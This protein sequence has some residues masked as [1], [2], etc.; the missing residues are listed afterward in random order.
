[1]SS[2]KAPKGVFHDPASGSFLQRKKASLGN[3][4]HSGDEKNVFLKSGSGASIYSDMESLSGNN[5]NVSMSGGFDGFLL[6][7]AVNTPKTKRVNTGV[8]FG[9]PIGSLD[10]K[11]DEEVKPLP[12]PLRKKVLLDKIWINSKV[13]KTPVE[14]SVKK[15]FALDI[16]LSAVEGKSAMKNFL[17]NQWFWGATTPLKFKGII[18]SMFTSEK[19]MEMAASLAREN[20]IVINTNLKK[21]GV[22]SDRAVVIKEI[23]MDTPK[24]IIVATA[25]EFGEIRSIKIQLIGIWQ[26]AVIEFTEL[27]QAELLVSKWSFL[28]GKNSV[29]VAMAVG[30]LKTTAHNLGTLLDRTGGRT[31]IINHSLD[32]GSRFCCAV[33]GFESERDL[34]SA[35]YT[36][37]I[38]G[39]VRL[40]WARL[41]LVQCG[42]C[43]RF[44]HLALEY[45][46]STNNMPSLSLAKFSK[47]FV[48][49]KRHLQ[50]AKLYPFFAS[51]LW[52]FASIELVPLV[53]SSLTCL[54]NTSASLALSLDSD[55]V[56]D[57]ASMLSAPHPSFAAIVGKPTLGLSSSKVLTGK[58]KD[59]YESVCIFTSGL[60]IG[61]LSAGVAIIMNNSLAHY[62]SKVEK[63]S[64]QVVAVWLLFKNKLSVSV[65]GLYAVNFLITKAVNSSTFVVL[66]E[67]F[68][69]NGSRRSA[70]FR[71]CLSLGLVNS[72]FGHP[73][74]GTTTWDNSRRVER[75]I[76]FIFVSENLVSAVAGHRVG[77]VSDFFDTNYNAVM[78]SVGLDGLLNVHLNS[79]CK[80]TNKDHWKFN[81]KN[82]NVTGQSRFRNCSSVMVL[83]MKDDFLAA[84]AEQDLDCSKNK[85]SSKFLC[86]ELLIIKIVKKFSTANTLGFN[87][88]VRKWSTLDAD[89]AFVLMDIVQSGWKKIAILKFLSIIK[90]KYRKFKLYESKLAQKASIREAIEKHMEKFCSDKSSMIRSVLD[91]PF[92][93]V[94][95][96]HL[97]IDDELVLEPKE[98]MPSMLPDL[99]AHQ[100]A[101]LAHVK[102]NAFFGVMSTITLDELLLV[103]GGL[104]NSKAAGLSGISNKLWKWGGKEVMKCLLVLLNVY[105]SVGSVPAVLTNTHPITLIEMARK[106]LSKILSDRI[107]F[108]CSRFG[109]LHGDNFLVLK[110]TS[111]QFPVFAVGSVVKNALEKN[112]ELLHCI[113]M[114]SRFIDFFGSIYE[115][116]VN[117][118]MTDFGF[119]S[120]YR[121]HDGLDQGEVFS[122]LLWRIF[123]DLLLCKVKRHEYLCGYYIDTKFVARTDRIENGGGMSSFFAA[124]TF[125]D[126]MIWIRDCQAS[127]QYALNIASE[128]F[129]IND[130]S[131][132]NEKRV[133]IPINQG[134]KI[135][136]LSINNQPISITKK[137]KA[138]RYLGI[139]LSTEEL[140]K[141]SLAKT[142]SDVCF[143]VNRVLRK[144]IVSY[145]M[146]FSFISSGICCKWDV[147]VRKGFRS[148]TH[149]PRH[150]PD[151]ALHHSS[152]YGLKSFEQVQSEEKMAFLVS[153]ANASSVLGHLFE[154]RFLDLQVLSWTPLNSFQYPIKLCVSLV[155][156]F[157]VGVVK[158]LMNIDLSLVNNLLNAFCHPGCFPMSLILGKSLY[159]NSVHSLK[160]F[161][162]V[163]DP[164][165]LVPLWFTVASKYFLDQ[166]FFSSHLFVAVQSGGLNILKSDVFSSMQDSLHEIWSGCFEAYTDG[167]LKGAGSADVLSGAAAYFPALGLGVG[168]KVC[169]FLSS[170]MV[171]LQA[172]ALALKCVPSSSSVMLYLNSQAAID[173]CISEMLLERRHVFDLIKDKDLSVSWVKV[174]GHAGVLGNMEADRFAR[175]AAGSGQDVV[176]A[177]MLRDFD[178][179][180][181][182]KIWHPDSH[183]LAG[184]TSCKSVDFHTYLIKALHKRLLIAVR[185]RLYNRCYSDVQCLLCGEVELLD[186]VFTCSQDVHIQGKILLEASARWT[187]LVGVHNL[188][189]SSVL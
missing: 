173:A 40:S 120:G 47:D 104:P 56:L 12:S 87:Y 49:E 34:D 74:V 83:G 154:H 8:N 80:Q 127:M 75:T 135:A 1:M 170:T 45:D 93:K 28:I 50:L 183:M 4:K 161:G 61:F 53:S 152:L 119:L 174:K 65:I 26:K 57:G 100:Y 24:E 178:W 67:D 9:S 125:V 118:V 134:I 155:N 85:Q 43:E 150:F 148:K 158:I 98:M 156:N 54:F 68:N 149:L 177:N 84:A 96:N 112:R 180:A 31:C 10:F 63:V 167:S 66:G 25:A 186:Y 140:S 29:C 81:I 44:G 105:L 7:S 157:L 121:V 16:N 3:V 41:D 184:F 15:L 171:K 129:Y 78:V 165:G 139:F 33:V 69:K 124:G 169:G 153:F 14:V 115:D 17:N 160:H 11:M 22:H 122:S 46:A 60:D 77:L 30:D 71:F 151:A 64:G 86:L 39:G 142:H 89:K 95:L 21:Q 143:F 109:I 103:V 138:H 92:R 18:R 110:G 91:W 108:V 55:I 179:A 38:F 137:S 70:S 51:W 111:T 159:F 27:G 5:N 130:I 172:V 189:S 35:F 23:L 52:H 136:T 131:I 36:E 182:V 99:W 94:V 37:P 144:L 114:C 147:L 13:I 141:P 79:L 102:D 6:D 176:L 42:R 88:F 19:S 132:N 175:E 106:I 116:R 76:D 72:F 188:F 97:V 164:W 166:S 133:A 107:S 123:Y 101:L 20:K 126:N 48:S 82:A 181:F 32:T 146:Q 59:K 185:K 187:S 162:V 145:H 163:F 62:V 113:K 73:L 2:K 58:I 128:F 168:V 90:K 117:K